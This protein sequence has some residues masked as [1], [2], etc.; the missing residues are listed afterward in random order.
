MPLLNI[1]LYAVQGK[2]VRYYVEVGS[3]TIGGY[4]QPREVANAMSLAHDGERQ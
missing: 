3:S 2:H 4:R 1:N